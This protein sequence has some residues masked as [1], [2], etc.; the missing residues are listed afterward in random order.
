MRQSVLV[1]VVL[2]LFQ[3]SNTCIA[4]PTLKPSSS[5]VRPQ[6]IQSD[7]CT[8]NLLFR[9]DSTYMLMAKLRMMLS[10]D[11]VNKQAIL[12]SKPIYYA[13][14]G[15][16]AVDTIIVQLPDLTPLYSSSRM[17]RDITILY[18]DKNK[19]KGTWNAIDQNIQ[20]RDSFPTSVFHFGFL[21]VLT[22]WLTLEENKN[23]VLT[24][25]DYMAGRKNNLRDVS[26]Q[27]I[28]YSTLGTTA[29]RLIKVQELSGQKKNYTFYVDTL[30][31][32]L[33]RY[34]TEDEAG[35]IR[36]VREGYGG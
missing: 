28:G 2:L 15:V 6:L 19:V 7:S 30:S 23:Y 29:V 33:L 26:V 22:G 27:F 4:Q 24:F 31:G 11:T 5:L 10:V 9:K 20:I 17:N 16:A 32:K 1:F 3:I 8:M 14:R 36:M 21:P 12:S 34:D 13:S 18:F 35:K 25:Y